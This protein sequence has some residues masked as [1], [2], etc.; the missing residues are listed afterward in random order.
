MPQRSE[1]ESVYAE[2]FIMLYHTTTIPRDCSGAGHLL[3][4]EGLC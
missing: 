2:K 4:D 1:G 3:T